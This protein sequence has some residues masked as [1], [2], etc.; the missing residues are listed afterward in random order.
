MY[1]TYVAQSI[2]FPDKYY[3]GHTENLEV[4]L[5]QH[6]SGMTQSIRHLIP[7]KIVY[8]ES[9]DDLDTSIKTEKY[10]KTAAGRRY[11][12]TKISQGG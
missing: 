12:K 1:F 2:E 4:R 5:V 9:F 11:L 7:V 10:W 6:N 8:Y 3:K